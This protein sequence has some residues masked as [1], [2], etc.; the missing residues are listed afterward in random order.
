MTDA[1]AAHFPVSIKG[2]VK[3]EGLFALLKNERDEWELP[4]GKLEKG[5]AI[6]A[7]LIREIKEELNLSTRIGR[8]LNN[9]VYFVNDIHVVIVTYELHIVDKSPDLKLSHEHKE[10]RLF[11]PA[12]IGKLRMP[13]GYKRSIELCMEAVQ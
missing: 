6:E 9:W 4:G 13:D 1:L 2:V 7:C 12:D 11:Q 5:E 8:P 10:L 3:H